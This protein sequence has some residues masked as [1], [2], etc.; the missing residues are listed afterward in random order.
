VVSY[1]YPFGSRAFHL[2]EYR[3]QIPGLT[4]PFRGPTP[5][6]SFSGSTIVQPRRDFKPKSLYGAI[7]D[8][9]NSE[10]IYEQAVVK[11]NA[12]FVRGKAADPL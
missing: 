4:F 11:T 2:L 3:C 1:A 6:R 8:T 12:G 7:V 10:D 9:G 5:S